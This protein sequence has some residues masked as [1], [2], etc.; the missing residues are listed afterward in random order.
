MRRGLATA[1][2]VLL[3]ILP[4]AFASSVDPSAPTATEALTSAVE[5]ATREKKPIVLVSR[6][7]RCRAS[8]KGVDPCRTLEAAIGHPAIARRLANIVYLSVDAPDSTA[9]VSVL[10]PGGRQIIRWPVPSDVSSVR[11]MLTLVEGATP[12]ILRAFAARNAGDANLAAREECLA[13]LALGG[14]AQGRRRLE[15]LRASDDAESRELATIWLGR[16]DER[17]GDA[18][19][20]ESELVSLAKRG[21][22]TRVRFEASMALGERRLVQGR[23]D[24]AVSLFAAAL[25]LAPDSG[26][27]RDAA[28]AALARSSESAAPVIGLGPPGAIVAGLRTLQP[29]WND[30]R[31]TRVEYRL[32]GRL[33]ATARKAPFAAAVKFDRVPARRLLEIT[34]LDGKGRTVRSASVVVNERSG[35]FAVQIVEPAGESLSGTTPVEATLR[36]PRGRAVTQ[37]AVEWNGTTVASLDTPPWK[38]TI[39]AEADALGVLRVVA[40]LDDGE[41]REDVRVFNAGDMLLETGVHLVE[42]PVVDA[43]RKLTR[44]DVRL[45]EA[46][47]VRPVESVISAADAP[48][49]VALLLDM[50]TSM[51]DYVLDLEEAAIEFVDT[52]L[53]KRARVTVVAFDTA[54]RVALWPTNDRARI[55]RAIQDLRI[56]GAT[57]LHDAMITAILQLQAGGSRRAIVVLSDGVDN[58]SIFEM[59]DVLEV[60][61]RNAVPVYVVTLNPQFQSPPGQNYM[62]MIRPEVKAQ[63]KL[64]RLAQ[65]SGGMA[66]ELRSVERSAPIWEKIADDLRNQSIVIYRTARGAGGWRSLDVSTTSGVRMRAPEGVFVE[67]DSTTNEAVK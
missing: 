34:A 52:S 64:A 53:E 27:E 18:G 66:F 31:V 35:A 33:V 43:N 10:D 39:V 14:E 47:V 4:N 19:A 20:D 16:L 54:A 8:K 30:A 56:R 24:E 63:K 2:V 57:A 3:G 29:K 12:N 28:L 17:S 41:E 44:G 9:S 67:G 62:P 23:N 42:I 45:K 49:D 60:A 5:R 51:K 32:D 59:G 13:I 11:Q 1:V 46:G 37:L 25:E 15:E 7:E 40:K 22:A 38:A 55:E 6:P 50:S 58:A 26:P 48:L 21:A 61:K 36:V 65:S